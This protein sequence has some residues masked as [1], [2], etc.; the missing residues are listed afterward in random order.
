MDI[1]SVQSASNSSPTA[2]ASLTRAQGSLFLESQAALASSASTSSLVPSAIVTLGASAAAQVFF[3]ATGLL[4]TPAQGNAATTAGTDATG[5]VANSAAV[6][7]QSVRLPGGLGTV[8]ELAANTTANAANTSFLDVTGTSVA[9][10][11]ASPASIGVGAGTA[12]PPQVTTPATSPATA[13]APATAPATAAVTSTVLSAAT[14][15]EQPQLPSSPTPLAANNGTVTTAALNTLAS[16]NPTLNPIATQALTNQLLAN[17]K[18][19]TLASTV[20]ANNA[21]AVRTAISA[22]ATSATA[23]PPTLAATGTSTLGTAPTTGGTA[24]TPSAAG[25]TPLVTVASPTPAPP[26]STAGQAV[27]AL[28]TPTAVAATATPANTPTTDEIAANQFQSL[29]NDNST[30]AINA[31]ATNPAYA[32]AAAALYLSAAVFRSQNSG[33][34]TNFDAGAARTVKPIERSAPSGHV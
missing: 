16:A 17:L 27:A 1:S 31:V 22:L 25:T 34:D 13:T 18:A 7:L 3:N 33:G 8:L 14:P 5:A 15:T 21:A 32:A 2:A 30:V 12:S 24:G 9:L 4:Q 26:P 20:A 19:A 11:A 28:A 23:L 10:P 29:V 6:Q